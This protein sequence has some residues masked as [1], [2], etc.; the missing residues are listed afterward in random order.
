LRFDDVGPVGSDDWNSAH[1]GAAHFGRGCM[2]R[3]RNLYTHRGGADDWED[4]EALTALSLL[5]RWIDAA[6]V[7]CADG[8]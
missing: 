3:I 1:D 2:L 7:D 8:V 6:R 4:L 5:A